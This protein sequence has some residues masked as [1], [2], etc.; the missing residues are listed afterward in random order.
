[1]IL[2]PQAWGGARRSNPHA[3]GGPDPR[4]S[5][6]ENECGG[7]RRRLQEADAGGG[8]RRRRRKERRGGTINK[9]NLHQG[10][11]KNFETRLVAATTRSA[12]ESGGIGPAD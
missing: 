11:K 2:G 10:V 4:W 3:A 12:P 5:D 1:M 6:R 8:C 9:Q 7:C